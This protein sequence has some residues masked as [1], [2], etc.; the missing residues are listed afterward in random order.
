MDMLIYGQKSINYNM[1]SVIT[2]H[3]HLNYDRSL[4]VGVVELVRLFL[5]GAAHKVCFGSGDIYGDNFYS[6]SFELNI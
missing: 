2:C 1:F 6:R 4:P 5:F 3:P